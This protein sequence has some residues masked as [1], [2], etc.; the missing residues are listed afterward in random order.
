MVEIS[1]SDQPA[2]R[3][4]GRVATDLYLPEQLR[5]IT[6]AVIDPTSDQ[7]VSQVEVGADGSLQG[8]LPPHLRGRELVVAL[9]QASGS[10]AEEVARLSFTV[11]T[12]GDASFHIPAAV[13][14]NQALGLR[15]RILTAELL[16][17]RV[18][19]KA[20]YVDEL[21]AA[22]RQAFAEIPHLINERLEN[23]AQLPKLLDSLFQP[24]LKLP[25]GSSLHDFI[26]DHPVAALVG[27]PIPRQA[28]LRL[29]KDEQTSVG[30]H[31]TLWAA[32]GSRAHRFGL[33]RKPRLS[34]RLEVGLRVESL[35]LPADSV[36]P[37]PSTPEARPELTMEE[38]ASEAEKV[39][40]AKTAAVVSDLVPRPGE[41]TTASDLKR[42][43][44]LANELELAD[45]AANVTAAKDVHVL[46]LGYQTPKSRKWGKAL[47]SSIK[48]LDRLHIELERNTGIKL[49]VIHSAATT[50]A[51]LEELIDDSQRLLQRAMDLE[52]PPEAVGRVFPTVN[53]AVWGRLSDESRITLG[54]HALAGGSATPPGAMQTK[55]FVGAGLGFILGGPTGAALG[56]ALEDGLSNSGGDEEPVAPEPPGI[57]FTPH[58]KPAPY[59]P[60]S[61]SV[62]ALTDATLA[63]LKRRLRKGSYEFDIYEPGSVNYGLMLTY[64]QEWSPLRYQVGR[65]IDTIPL[66]PGEKRE[67]RVVTTRK[68]HDARA[69]LT[70]QTRESTNESSSTTRL[71]SEAIEAATMAVNNQFSA[72]GS[73][74]IGVGTI[75][76]STDFKLN[77]TDE[78]RRT[79]K[80]FSELARK[81]VD[82]LKNQIEVKVDSSEDYSSEISDLR[83]ITNTNNEIT[84]TYLLYELERR[85]RV[86]TQL[87]A[88]RPVVLYAMD[89]PDPD[90][91]TAAW[92][93]EY[94]AQI[95]DFLLDPT[96]R[97]VLDDLEQTHSSADMDYRMAE[98][99]LAE[100]RQIY[101]ALTA[102]IDE[103]EAA[104]ALL[105][106]EAA[107]AAV[108]AAAAKAAEPGALETI[109]E[110]A[111][112]GPL[113]L[114]FGPGDSTDDETLDARARANEKL[115]QEINRRLDTK[116][117]AIASAA[118]AISTAYEAYQVKAL[119]RS[120]SQL[121][122][123]RL[124]VHIRDNVFHYMH[125]I[126]STTH[127]DNR[128]F[129]LHDKTVPFHAPKSSDYNLADSPMPAIAGLLPG[130]DIL[131]DDK[132]LTI[133]KPADNA[134]IRR[135]LGEIADIDRPLGFRGN[136]V[137][138]ELRECSQLT[139]Y[140]AAEFVDPDTGVAAPGV[141]TGLS[142]TELLDYIET[143]IAHGLVNEDQL[144]ALKDLARRIAH[145][146]NDGADD[147]VL[148]TGQVMLE[149]I[150]G[151]TTLL[152][153]FKLVHRGIDVIAA[154]EE[155]RAKRLDALRRARKVATADLERD[156][157]T[158]ERF[159]L[160]EAP[161]IEP[162]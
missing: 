162:V 63:K 101:E 65:L 23:H 80:N 14:V 107:N 154:E 64:R 137:V 126:W 94:S 120:R 83:T 8:I 73:F 112:T 13:G 4:H 146:Q 119:A 48:D 40:L 76:G 24:I 109:A 71:E 92:I 46:Q 152:E 159:Y 160:G 53:A 28:R 59:A 54:T 115:V 135:Q 124:A 37:V 47:L 74:N 161:D 138:F 93:L 25:K 88:V 2:L 148:P 85:Y 31:P 144:E 142:T 127:P 79:L 133:N 49:P 43:H 81:S 52:E 98:S 42:L 91:I 62:M 95:R 16:K 113:S 9:N 22:R 104:V 130:L 121:A 57:S 67:V 140:M 17:A 19:E 145:E 82:T 131:G 41:P 3:F 29:T 87:A 75:G 51:E 86:E 116:R 26:L 108:G 18:A 27:T 7:V 39:V 122:E 33:R 125:G 151:E 90:E 141:I 20:Q 84:I 11:P 99:R 10:S 157:T 34:E 61:P 78:A 1:Q 69:S 5:R 129:E 123:S 58:E 35:N 32:L 106:S 100:Q 12:A 38:L 150:K 36:Q 132:I 55:G 134:T 155:V 136:F 156:P 128:Y 143:A 111:L 70:N 45:G 97:Q 118:G 103:L 30:Q 60:L 149:A 139:D 68:K 117:A 110:V 147:F 15:G 153:P 6:A 66:T 44:N 158:V 102:E 21:A 114:L 89:M 72:N 105:T 77:T 50:P 56:S 96:L